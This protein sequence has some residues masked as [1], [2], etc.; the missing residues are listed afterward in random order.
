MICFLYPS[1]HKM[2]LFFILINNLFRK[3]IITLH[4]NILSSKNVV[5]KIILLQFN[6]RLLNIE[7]MFQRDFHIDRFWFNQTWILLFVLLEWRVTLSI[8]QII[9]MSWI[10]EPVHLLNGNQLKYNS[11]PYLNLFINICMNITTLES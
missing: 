7:H 2:S 1:I 11:M 6:K 3:I 8:Q 4:V 9:L 5:F 10:K